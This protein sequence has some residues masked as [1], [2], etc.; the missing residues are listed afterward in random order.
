MERIYINNKAFTLVEL[1]VTVAIIGILASISVALYDQYRLRAYEAETSTHALNFRTSLNAGVIQ[2]KGFSQILVTVSPSITNGGQVFAIP[3]NSV[4]FTTNDWQNYLP[5][6][7]PVPYI[8]IQGQLY[9]NSTS[10]AVMSYVVSINCKAIKNSQFYSYQFS[11]VVASNGV[12]RYLPSFLLN[13]RY[14]LSC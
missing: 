6:Y 12:G 8:K 11:S 2:G 1:L 13:A 3:L 14:G 10:S 5:G 7:T 4:N 9:P